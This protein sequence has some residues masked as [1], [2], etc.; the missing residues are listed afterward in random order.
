MREKFLEILNENCFFFYELEERFKDGLIFRSLYNKLTK[1]KYNEWVEIC[2]QLQKSYDPSLRNEIF[3]TDLN[4]KLT[5][6]REDNN[7]YLK[8]IK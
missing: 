8:I 2:T 5:L 4:T 3:L 1:E 6:I 7:T